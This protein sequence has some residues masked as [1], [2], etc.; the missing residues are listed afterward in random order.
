MGIIQKIKHFLYLDV[1]REESVSRKENILHTLARRLYLSV[2]FFVER[3][4]MDYT[5][6]LSFNTVL[7]IV[8]V[9]AL[10]FAVGKG[11]GLSD[12]IVKVIHEA[13]GAQP[14]V[15]DSLIRLADSYLSHAQTG[16]IIGIGLVIML[17]SIF[18]L[19]YNV[20][21]VFDKIWQVKTKRSIGQVVIDYTAMIFLVPIVIIVLS[22]IGIFVYGFADHIPNF[23]GMSYISM[24]SINILIPWALLSCI[25]IALNIMVPNTHIRFKAVWFPSILEGGA[26]LLLQSFFVNGQIFLTSYNAIYGS[27]AVLPLFMLWMLA[28]WYI[29]LFCAEI[30]YLNQNE[31]YYEYMI[32]T[33]DI[34]HRKLMMYSGLILGKV[35]TIFRSEERTVSALELSKSTL[36][37]IRVV[38]DI[39]EDLKNVKLLRETLDPSTMESS[40][41][42]V[43]DTDKF[44]VGMLRNRL[45][46]YA[47]KDDID[48]LLPEIRISGKYKQM[49]ADIEDDIDRRLDEIRIIDLS[50][51]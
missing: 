2:R 1:W 29:I 5:T 28:S 44:T 13:L 9:S 33:R 38:T 19:I 43:T 15:A 20:E 22:G 32:R 23:R 4:H 18:S 17:Y 27:L 6:Q 25:F 49:F 51:E 12:Y 50:S 14:Q 46:N 48:E 3:G 31:Q 40:W 37:P 11:F 24:I 35:C 30:C 21:Y 39:L 10:L 45:E 8:P 34:S 16:V 42:P 26:M 41:S 47:S 7:A 36:I